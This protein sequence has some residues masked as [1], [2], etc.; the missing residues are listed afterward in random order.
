M[1]ITCRTMASLTNLAIAIEILSFLSYLLLVESLQ[2][3]SNFVYNG[4]F[5]ANLSLD[6]ASFVRSN[7]ILS[8]TNDISKLLGHSF[9]PTLLQFKTGT[10]FSTNF[11][12][13]ILPKYPGLGG[14]GLTFGL[15]SKHPLKGCLPNQYLGLPNVTSNSQTSTRILAVEF[16]AVQYIKFQDINNNHVGIDISNLVSNISEL[17]AYYNSNDENDHKNT[18]IILKSGDP[19]QAW[20]DYDGLQKLQNVS[21]SPLG[22]GRPTRPLISFSIDLSRVLDEYMYMGFSASTGLC[23]LFPL[24]NT[25][26]V[27]RSQRYG[28]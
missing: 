22:I 19:L 3:E 25:T 5:Q 28:P 26:I 27:F 15:T 14:H 8:I 4:F 11:V 17:A 6:G 7:G 9:Y 16:D 12:F 20:I 21:L 10:N 23:Y 1:I 18:T 13:S 24:L 2:N